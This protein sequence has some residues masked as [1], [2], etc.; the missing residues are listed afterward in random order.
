MR[1]PLPRVF[2]FCTVPLEDEASFQ[3]LR[4]AIQEQLSGA[5]VYTVGDEPERQVYVV[6]KT[7]D[8]KWARLKTSVEET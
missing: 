7:R 4:Q 6:G 8:G 3:E 2:V 1:R 5:K